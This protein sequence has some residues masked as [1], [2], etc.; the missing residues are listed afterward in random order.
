MIEH[1]CHFG[2]DGG[3]LWCVRCA[4]RFALQELVQQL[5]NGITLGSV[6]ALIALGYTMVYGILELINFAHG[7]VFM[8]GAFVALGVFVVLGSAGLP[9]WLLLLAALLCAM[10]VCSLLGMGL[11]R[12]A[13]RP[14]LSAAKP[15]GGVELGVIAAAGCGVWWLY[16]QLKGG[17]SQGEWLLGPVAGLGAAAAL[18]G[19]FAYLGRSGP[20]HRT[21][22]LSLLIT[23]LG[24]SILLQNAMRLIVG[25]RDRIL[26]EVLPAWSVTLLGVQI[27]APQ[28]LTVGVSVA[29]MALLTWLVQSTR[30]GKA[31]RATAQDIEA[32]QLMGINTRL[33][34][35][36]VFILGSSLAAV[37]GV[38]F[39]IF[40]K[41]INFFIGFQAGLKA[42]TAAVL[43]GIGNIPGAVLGGLLLGLLESL[44]SGYL[45]SEWKDVF[46]FIVL[47]GVLLLRPSGLL[48]ENVPEKV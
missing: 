16:H 26:P 13:Y 42:F 37:A 24:A 46:A 9:W 10:A 5:V 45:S 20:V 23:A 47:V 7:E 25:S 6:Y 17:L 38:L 11:E 3:T 15:L 34:I 28:M 27:T 35:V 30:L 41:S 40:F 32:A 33:I 22:R 31:M 43:G 4:L 1:P 14:L 18:W 48:G 8:V 36:V 21:P 39:A 19:L 44:G 12:L 29:A 2:V